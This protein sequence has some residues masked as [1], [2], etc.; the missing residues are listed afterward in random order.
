MENISIALACI[1]L[2]A[3]LSFLTFQRNKGK[4]IRADIR[5]E[6]RGAC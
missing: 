6:E 1:L 3:A 5:E 2:G 4:D